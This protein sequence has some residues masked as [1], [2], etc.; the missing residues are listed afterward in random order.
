MVSMSKAKHEPKALP[1]RF[2]TQ[3]AVVP[4]E[5]A[6][7]ITL[8]GKTIKTPARNLLQVKAQH[9]AAAIATEWD[10]QKDVIDPD[11]MPLTRL[12]HIALDRVEQDRDAL[13]ADIAQYV[14]TDLLCYRA[15]VEQGNP[16]AADNKVLRKRQD[17]TFDPILAWIENEFGARF[18]VTE[19]LIA[20]R[21]PEESQRII[22]AEF[23]KASH[24]ELAALAMMVPM[25]GSA[26]LALAV[27]NEKLDHD[28]ALKAARLDEEAQAERW[29]E[30]PLARA[31]WAAK[32]RDIRAAVFYLTG[33]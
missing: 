30:D 26:L 8:D 14:E 4:A 17:A 24:D 32:A 5:G 10:A 27:W 9:I 18:E 15:P 3:V 21:Q 6:H 16:L 31:A 28:A 7:A 11:T 19:G 22:A 1:K 2:Y 13:L 33:K 23:A 20:V 25:L 29:G 12:A